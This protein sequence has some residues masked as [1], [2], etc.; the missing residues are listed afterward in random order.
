M[1]T[2]FTLLSTLSFAALASAQFG[3]ATTYAPGTRPSGI[4]LAD[5]DGDGDVDMAV[6]SD[7]PDKIAV[8]TNM[9]AGTFSGPVMVLL[10]AGTSPQ[11]LMARDFDGDGDIDLAVSLK[12][13][14]AVQMVTN[15]GGAFFPGAM[16]SIAGDEPRSMV[17][18]D[19]DGDGDMDLVT[20]NRKTDNVSVLR[21]SGGSLS[22]LGTFGAG[23][24]PRKLTAADFDLDGDVDIAVSSHDDRTL[25]VLNNTG[26]GNLVLGMT[27]SVGSQIRPDG[28]TSADLN[29]DGRMDLIAATSG[30]NA[31]LMF[32]TVFLNMGGSWMGPFNYAS[33]GMNPDSVAAAD[34]DLDG[35]IDL[36]LSNQDS[37]TVAALSNSG[38]GTF[39]APALSMTGSRPG[40]VRLADLDGNSSPDLAVADRDS[41]DVMVFLNSNSGG[42]GNVGTNYCGP[43]NANSTGMGAQ[44]AGSGS[45]VAAM[46]NLTLT[47]TQMPAGQF[48]M[49][50]N[51]PTQGFTQPPGSQGNLCLGGQIGRHTAQIGQ[52][53]M[54]GSFSRT[55]D[56]TSLPR[57]V[58]GPH[59]VVAGE[60]WNFQ[61]WFRDGSFSNFTDGL[62]ITFL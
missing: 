7:A 12:N 53:A 50:L 32:A 23:S 10:G 4:A 5:F 14:N 29:A 60:T 58:G 31:G 33:G 46:N 11:A 20:S 49:F 34:L 52:V 37:N 57:P 38:S 16:T 41:N 27:L 62:S 1:R 55:I 26:G 22:L 51:S 17:A 9:G 13:A 24:G 3:G 59:S 28:L 48:A 8:F 2:A 45:A 56:L 39:G 18:A 43:A 54:D 36:V 35:D 25:R 6:T 44:L 15:V 42:G 61:L 30:N 40:D 19:L 21:N 47:G